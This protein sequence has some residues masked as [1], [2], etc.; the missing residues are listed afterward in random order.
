[1]SLFCRRQRLIHF[2]MSDYCPPILKKA[3]KAIERN[4]DFHDLDT[5]IDGRRFPEFEAGAYRNT[6]K[7]DKDIQQALSKVLL[8]SLSSDD[9]RTVNADTASALQSYCIRGVTYR[10]FDKSPNHSLIYFR[11]QGDSSQQPL[12][13]LSPGQIRLLF[14]HYRVAGKDIITETFAAVH[15][16]LPVDLVNNPFAAFP[17][18]RAQIF[19]KEPLPKVTVIRASQ[20]YCHAN[21]RPWNSSS[22]VMRAINRVGSLLRNT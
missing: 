8:P 11:A 13:D 15:Q 7:L 18:F 5:G 3:W 6:T 17:D 9:S 10:S 20:I 2:T 21:Q 22:V 12:E 14:Q 4:V 1:M 19:H 16:Y